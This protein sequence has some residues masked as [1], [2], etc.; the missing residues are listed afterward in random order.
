MAGVFS[1]GVW[2]V[3]PALRTLTSGSREVHLEPKPMQVL[4]VLAEHAGQVVT[5]DRLLQAVWEGTFVGDEV[6][7]RAISELRRALEDDPKT[8]RFI[9]TIPK[10]GYRLVAPVKFQD[11]AAAAVDRPA[12]SGPVSQPARRW[13]N[14]VLWGTVIAAVAGGAWMFARHGHANAP[15][16]PMTTR[17]AVTLP[18]RTSAPSFSPDG[19]RITFAWKPPQADARIVVKMVDDDPVQELTRSPGGFDD[20]SPAWSPDGRSIAFERHTSNWLPDKRGGLYVIPAIGGRE[21]QVYSGLVSSQGPTWAPD[22]RALVFAA[23]RT[24]REKSSLYR[25]SLDT[26]ESARL[27]SSDTPDLNRD[28]DVPACS[29][30]GKNIAFVVY[31]SDYSEDVYLIPSQGGAATRLTFDA[32]A[33]WGRVAWTPDAKAILFESSRGGSPELWRVPASGGQPER[34][35]AAA[36]ALGG[37]ALDSERRRLAYVVRND[38]VHIGAFSLRSPGE[39]PRRIAESTRSEYGA[40]FSPDGTRI[41]FVSNRAGDAVDIWVSDA[42]GTNQTRLT[43]STRGFNASQQWSPDGEWLAYDSDV[44][45]F[46]YDVYL[47]RVSGGSPRRLTSE[48]SSDYGP[49][50]SRDGRWL[51]FASD[52]TGKEQIYKMPSAGGVAV[53]VTKGGGF[54]PGAESADGRFLYYSKGMGQAGVWRVPIDGGLEEPVIRTYPADPLYRSWV[55]VEDGIYYLNNQDKKR[56]RLDFLRFATGRV[57]QILELPESAGADISISPDRRT[58]LTC[59][60]GPPSD[61]IFVVDNFH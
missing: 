58:L 21:R 9:Q 32:K 60:A 54:P 40:T 50:W 17:P 18:G 27:M 3:D 20:D 42:D 37:V 33:I 8:P 16:P 56:S 10:G 25:L 59:W 38:G 49:T 6:L 48:R 1:V 39:P 43:T 45:D 14:L 29:P 19:T 11:P 12:E 47:I 52:R 24:H 44:V 5:K 7:S 4:V 51:Y 41:A 55:L 30:D 2:Y 57:E 26:L 13:R 23:K 36:N 34:L 61:Q 22:G 53:Q 31:F 35:S 15:L 28:V 46:Q